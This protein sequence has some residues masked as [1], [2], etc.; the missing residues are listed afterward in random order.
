MTYFSLVQCASYPLFVFLFSGLVYCIP[1]YCNY[2]FTTIYDL[3]FTSSI[4]S[5]DAQI[6]ARLS[7]RFYF[8]F[9]SRIGS[10]ANPK[11]LH[12]M[13]GCVW[14]QFKSLCISPTVQSARQWLLTSKS[15]FIFAGSIRM[16]NEQ[17]E[18]ITSI[19]NKLF[20]SLFI[21]FCTQREQR[22]WEHM[23]AAHQR[24]DN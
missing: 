1:H 13:N 6:S 18:R 20:S 24:R 14:R 15:H 22:R 17:D 2:V 12:T 5:F 7:H 19:S 11:N 9:F 23:C 4:I 16:D 10:F 8:H 3:R 21:T